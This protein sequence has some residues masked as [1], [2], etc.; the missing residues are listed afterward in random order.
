MSHNIYLSFAVWSIQRFGS[1][2][3]N[4]LIYICNTISETFSV[5][6]DKLKTLIW[7]DNLCQQKP[8]EPW[9]PGSHSLLLTLGPSH[10]TKRFLSKFTFPTYSESFEIANLGFLSLTLLKMLSNE[11]FFNKRLNFLIT[12]LWQLFQYNSVF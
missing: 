3:I 4:I 9:F 12:I 10:L 6:W 5:F 8:L 1:W 2:A 11:R 7:L